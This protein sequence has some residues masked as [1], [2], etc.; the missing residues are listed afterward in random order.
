MVDLAQ[1]QQGIADWAI[2]VDSEITRI[3]NR[4]NEL[5][6]TRL[7]ALIEAAKSSEQNI[8]CRDRIWSYL[9]ICRVSS[10]GECQQGRNLPANVVI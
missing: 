7:A 6:E 5:V 4:D 3:Q 8:L 10:V 9:G 1:L 2:R